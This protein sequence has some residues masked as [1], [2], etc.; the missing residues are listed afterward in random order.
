[1]PGCQA[2]TLVAIIHVEEGGGFWFGALELRFGFGV[3]GLGF[4]PGAIAPPKLIQLKSEE[5]AG[6]P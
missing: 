3:L 6:P 1:M 2:C 5:A 4:G